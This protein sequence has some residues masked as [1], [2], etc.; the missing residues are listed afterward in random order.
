MEKGPKKFKFAGTPASPTAQSYLKQHAS[1]IL[2]DVPFSRLAT[3]HPSN[4][5]SAEHYSACSSHFELLVPSIFD[6]IRP[7]SAKSGYKK[8]K[9]L[10]VSQA[11]RIASQPFV[12]IRVHPWLT[13]SSKQ[14]ITKRTHFQI[15]N[16]I[17]AQQ[18]TPIPAWCA[19]KNEPISL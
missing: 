2:P 13:P 15:F 7:N 19:Q 1:D 14:K 12:F 10:I 3:R 4:L 17:T 11:V 8:I 9:I 16:T 18:L 5:R 6:Q